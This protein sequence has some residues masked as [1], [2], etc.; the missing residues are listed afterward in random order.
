MS[1]SHSLHQTDLPVQMQILNISVNMARTANIVANSYKQKLSL[2][3]KFMSQ[4][5]SYLEDL[6]LNDVSKSFRPT[7]GRFKKEFERLK[8]Q[9]INEENKLEWSERALTW[10]DILQIRAKLT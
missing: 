7:L 9:N 4:T 5:E 8:K 1:N 3:E 6:S 10:A 2:V